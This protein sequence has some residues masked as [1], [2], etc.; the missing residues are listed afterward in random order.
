MLDCVD[1]N[2]QQLHYSV[3][4]TERNNNIINLVPPQTIDDQ[5]KVSRNGSGRIISD[6]EPKRFTMKEEKNFVRVPIIHGYG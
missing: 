5:I 3:R 2:R 6:P 1:T 4:D